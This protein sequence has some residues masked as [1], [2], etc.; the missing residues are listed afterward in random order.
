MEDVL[1]IGRDLSY[2]AF[3]CE[4]VQRQREVSFKVFEQVAIAA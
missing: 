1:L 3:L 2:F 4:G